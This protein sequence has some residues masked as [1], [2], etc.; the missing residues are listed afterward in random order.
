MNEEQKLYYV[1]LTGFAGLLLLQAALRIIYVFDNAAGLAVIGAAM[2]FCA[3]GAAT[4][5][6]LAK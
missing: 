5:Y 6:K 1:S 4:G 2:G 3:V